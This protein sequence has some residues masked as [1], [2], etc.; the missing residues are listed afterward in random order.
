VSSVESERVADAEHELRGPVAALALV[1]ERMRRDAHAREYV[2]PLEVQ[3]AR[4][5][6]A[7]DDLAAVRRGRPAAARE[8]PL[9]LEEIASGAAAGVIADVREDWR[10]GDA[11]VVADPG[12][13][14]QALGN[15]LA[16]ADEH[17]EGP[18]ELRGRRLPGAIRVEV[19]NR[20]RRTAAFER[21]EG[22]GRGLR[23][24]GQA[25]AAAGGRLEL[26]ED[27]A[28]V[29]ASLELPVDDPRGR[30]A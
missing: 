28:Q 2:Q 15:L 27:G 5:C 30:A 1:V 8:G 16:N 11:R 24:A 12:R 13:L 10:A 21:R 9:D 20:P 23:I 19:R 18:I 29:V 14:A 17:G 7:L 22:R 6:A 25:A 26:A 4:L 3:L